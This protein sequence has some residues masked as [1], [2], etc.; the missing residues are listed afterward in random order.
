[1]VGYLAPNGHYSA[2]SSQF[3]TGP[4]D[5]APL[6][7]IANATSVNGV[8]AYSTTSTFPTSSYSSSGY[9]VDLLFAPGS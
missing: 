8:Y 6:H 1:V 3:A 7:A 5:N 9:S 4:V 2:T